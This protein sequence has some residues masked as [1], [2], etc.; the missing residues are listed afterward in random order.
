M[1]SISLEFDDADTMREMADK[2]WCKH[3]I[4]GE[5]HM[6][7][8]GDVWILELHAEKTP[9]SKVIEQLKSQQISFD[10]DE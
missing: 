1:F 9:P 7:K 10:I 8:A 6:K 5:M 2:L 4:T 3:K